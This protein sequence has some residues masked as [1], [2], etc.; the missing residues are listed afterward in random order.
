VNRLSVHRTNLHIYANLIGPDA[1]VLVSASTVEA[2]V[3]AELAGN[4]A[5]VATPLPPH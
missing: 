1:K 3:R 2:E 5:R 4:R